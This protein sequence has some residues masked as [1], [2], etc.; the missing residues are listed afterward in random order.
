[1]NILLFSL[2]ATL[3]TFLGGLF[4]L[5]F[6]DKLHLILGF[7]AGAVLGVAFFD[8]LPESI[9][10]ASSSYSL[11][12]T[13]MVVA[14]GFVVFMVLD[15]LISLHPHSETDGNQNHRG[16]LGAGS[17][18][19]H[20]FMDGLV[21]GIAFQVSEAVGL[22]VTTAILAHDFSDGI[23]TVGLILKNKG[24][25]RQAAGWLFLDAIAPVAGAVSTM[26]F[27]LKESSLGI[28]LAVFCGFFLYIGA[29][30]L[31]PESYHH[32]PTFWT[33][34]MTIFGILFIFIVVKLAGL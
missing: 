6:K 10:L 12:F 8:L 1:M 33:T 16:K 20:S 27:S 28:V 32:H 3:S 17:V 4:A 24:T 11:S 13:I 14:I 22:V 9:E 30:D 19:I 25:T 21:I 31:L 5:W 29:G 26:F 34:A 18:T 15:R 23:N 2:G 7:S